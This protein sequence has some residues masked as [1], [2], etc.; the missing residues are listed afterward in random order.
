MAITRELVLEPAD[1]SRVSVEC[2]S[3]N[4][5]VEI[6]RESYERASSAQ[7]GS[8][9]KKAGVPAD[10]PSCD[11]KWREIGE[12]LPRFFDVLS[13]LEKYKVTFRIADPR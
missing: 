12:L 3:C 8:T 5:R 10:C 11:D 9:E 6:S 1:L 7:T 4:T 13:D 2:K